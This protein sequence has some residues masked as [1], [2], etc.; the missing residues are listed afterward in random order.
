MDPNAAAPLTREERERESALRA[1]LAAV[2]E[3]D[4]PARRRF[5]DLLLRARLYVP[6]MDDGGSARGFVGRSGQMVLPAFT[7]ESALRTYLT[8]YVGHASR[9]GTLPSASIFE[10]ALTTGMDEVAINLGTSPVMIL[11]RPLLEILAAGRNPD[12]AVTGG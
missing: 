6:V 5:Y 7:D 9:F 1:Y 2:T 3:G 12:G 8:L 11:Q 10:M 4:L